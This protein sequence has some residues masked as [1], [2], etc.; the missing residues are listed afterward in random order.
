MIRKISIILLLI[1]AGCSSNKSDDPSVPTD[2]SSDL[3]TMDITSFNDS[4]KI[5]S[6]MQAVDFGLVDQ[7]IKKTSKIIK[8]KNT[9]DRSINMDIV[10]FASNTGFTIFKNEQCGKSLAAKSECR[11]TVQFSNQGLYDASYNDGIIVVSGT[12]SLALQLTAQSTGNIFNGNISGVD[13]FS[14][15]LDSPFN[16]KGNTYRNLSIANIG[17]TRSMT[18]EQTF[19]AG[20]S[21]RITRCSSLLLVNQSCSMQIIYDSSLSDPPSGI[22]V[23]NSSTTSNGI[24]LLTGMGDIKPSQGVYENMFNYPVLV[25]AQTGFN[26]I[27][28]QKNIN[29]IKKNNYKLIIMGE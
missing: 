23:I 22:A 3:L 6:S 28:Y 27:H 26:L 17:T 10:P 4:Q 2:A 5:Q 29:Y 13:K 25:S 7:V 11:I 12:N 14:L 20:Y 19:P 15:S 8:I 9:G 21:I 1:L 18:L 24:D 16:L